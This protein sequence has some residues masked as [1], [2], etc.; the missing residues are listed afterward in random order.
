MLDFLYVFGIMLS[1]IALFLHL[2][3]FFFFAYVFFLISFI[4]LKKL[5][6]LKNTKTMCECV[7]WYLYTLDGH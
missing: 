5:K 7:Y 2:F 4:A 1:C 6:I 3:F